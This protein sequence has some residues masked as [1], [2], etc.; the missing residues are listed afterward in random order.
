MRPA[1]ARA[2]AA[3]SEERTGIYSAEQS[4][5]ELGA[6]ETRRFRA[7]KAA[8]Q[9][10]QAQPAGYRKTVIHWVTSARKAETQAR[11]LDTVI[12]DSAKGLRIGMLRRD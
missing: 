4:H 3:R 1:G 5:V 2:F 9:F 7:N 11:R 12:A 6:A 10:F 8:W